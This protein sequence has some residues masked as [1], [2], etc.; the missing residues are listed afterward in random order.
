MKTWKF[1][2]A[3][4]TIVAVAAPA[5]AQGDVITARRDGFKGVAR[6]MEGIKAVWWIS[7]AI[8]A[9]QAPP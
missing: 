9:P 7:A 8:R 3:L 2:A 1:A 5:W 4:V 6:H